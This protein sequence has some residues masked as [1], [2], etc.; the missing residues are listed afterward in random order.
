MKR[1][2]KRRPALPMSGFRAAVPDEVS[3]EVNGG[4]RVLIVSDTHVRAAI[5]GTAAASLEAAGRG[6]P[7]RLPRREGQQAPG[8]RPGCATPP[9]SRLP[10]RSGFDCGPGRR[11]DR[12][13]GGL[14]PPPICGGMVLCRFPPPCWPWWILRWERPAWIS[15]PGKTW[16]APSGSRGWLSW[17]PAP[18]R[19]A[20]CLFHRRVGKS[21]KYAC[22]R[23]RG[24]LTCW[25]PARR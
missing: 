16:W 18:W 10:F 1:I 7:V 25:N 9:G 2:G 20:P 3:R 15:R 24:C 14:P 8:H 23:D 5:A 19:P 17:I 12:R 22:I 6:V 13:H 11:R 21:S 4:S